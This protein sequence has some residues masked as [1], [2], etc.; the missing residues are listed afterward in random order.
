MKLVA[1][2]LLINLSNLIAS[3][4]LKVIDKAQYFFSYS[5]EKIHKIIDRKSEKDL[6]ITILLHTKW[7]NFNSIVKMTTRD[8]RAL[9]ITKLNNRTAET[10]TALN[11]KTNY[12]LSSY[13]LIYTFIKTADIRTESEL[14]SMHLGDLRNSL[15]VENLKYLN[16]KT[17]QNLQ[18]L[19]TKKLV[20]LGYSWYIPKNYNSF[21]NIDEL[22][23][24]IPNLQSTF[25]L[26]D[27]LGRTMNV[28]KIVKTSEMGND[29]FSYLGLYHIRISEDNFNLQ[30]AG[31][32][33]MFKWNFITEIDD[34]AHQ[35]DIVKWNEGYLIAYEEDKIQGANNIA[36]KYYTNYNN[37]ISNQSVYD[38]HLNTSIH[39]FGVE[40]TPD[41]RNVTGD[42]PV[43]GNILIGFHYYDGTIDKL[44]MGVLQNG[45]TWT[46][47]K[48]V[49]AE[50]NLRD[51]N[52]KGNIGSRKGFQHHGETLTLQEARLVKGDWSSW[53][54]MLGLNGY[55]TEVSIST[56]KESRSFAN[57]SITEIETNKY[58][59]SLFLP[60]EGNHYSENNGGVIFLKNK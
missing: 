51:Q 23:K 13:C 56:P 53:K 9:L 59:I 10:I 34:N 1:F 39:K 30:L 60:T 55:F 27:D 38:K 22:Q 29:K 48:D 33:D 6:L 41:I 25:K 12:E 37:L 42:S 26:K 46:T 7:V 40:G 32:N 18:T 8:L 24:S 21:V 44:A 45:K 2:I 52:F 47:W 3:K 17:L 14:K 20:Q 54:I 5:G 31:S 11:S 43:N 50:S 16:T 19:T 35:G 57:P 49:L 36:L 15:I 4:S 58:A 28:I